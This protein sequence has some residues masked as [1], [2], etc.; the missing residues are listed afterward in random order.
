[1]SWITPTPPDPTPPDVKPGCKREQN[2]FVGL[3]NIFQPVVIDRT[4]SRPHLAEDHHANN[5]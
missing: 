5:P 2:A 4:E 3:S 1:M